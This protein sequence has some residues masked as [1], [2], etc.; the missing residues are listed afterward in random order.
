[1]TKLLLPAFLL[2]VL[3]GNARSHAC[4]GCR[5]IMAY[6]E[7]LADRQQLID[8]L[9]A[10]ALDALRAVPVLDAGAVRAVRLSRR[11]P[12]C[13]AVSESG[14]APGRIKGPGCRR[15]DDGPVRRRGQDIQSGHLEYG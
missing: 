8:G 3:A 14:L 1:M 13:G 6:S 12:R 2:L 7:D 15:D 10:A 9:D 11:A 5:P 4:G